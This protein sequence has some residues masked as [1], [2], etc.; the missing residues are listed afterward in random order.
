MTYPETTWL[1]PEFLQKVIHLR[2]KQCGQS[3]QNDD[4][5]E[6]FPI[7]NSVNL[8]VIQT[9]PLLSIFFSMM[10]KQATD[11]MDGEDGAYVRYR[12]DGSLFILRDI[13][14]HTKTQK[15]LIRTLSSRTTLL[16][17][18]TWSKLRSALHLAL[19]TSLS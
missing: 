1:S 16:L 3:R 10:L 13:H 18:P 9:P 2:E 4:L 7:T 15:R 5:S 6:P 12:L 19:R 11:G 17:S 8:V 14:D